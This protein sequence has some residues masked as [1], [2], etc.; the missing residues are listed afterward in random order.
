MSQAGAD[1][2]T[3]RSRGCSQSQRAEDRFSRSVR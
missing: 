3:L 1:A 2:P